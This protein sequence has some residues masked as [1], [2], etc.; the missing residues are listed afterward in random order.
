MTNF[1]VESSD[2]FTDIAGLT[3]QGSEAVGS[4]TQEL[5]KKATKA[6]PLKVKD[7]ATGPREWLTYEQKCCRLYLLR[8]HL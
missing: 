6:G 4:W 5:F 2:D 7:S 1:R 8:W 3:E